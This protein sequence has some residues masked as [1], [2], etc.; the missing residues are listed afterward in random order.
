M[1]AGLL[2]EIEGEAAL[3]QQE[4]IGAVFGY[5]TAAAK[6]VGRRRESR[7]AIFESG[8][9]FTATSGATSGTQESALGYAQ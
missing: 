6:K 4:K 1:Q 9:R 3:T 2:T 7:K 5:N 8:G